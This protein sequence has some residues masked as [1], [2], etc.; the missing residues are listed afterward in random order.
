VV[1]VSIDVYEERIGFIIRVTRIDELG[2]ILAVISEGSTLWRY[3]VRYD[4]L[5]WDTRMKVMEGGCDA[6][7]LL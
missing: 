1:H 6:V 4:A 5:E 7:W 3:Y 2:T